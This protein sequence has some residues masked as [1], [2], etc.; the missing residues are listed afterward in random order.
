[1]QASGQLQQQAAQAAGTALPASFKA[2]HTKAEEGV[3]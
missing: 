2:Q 3:V 1:M